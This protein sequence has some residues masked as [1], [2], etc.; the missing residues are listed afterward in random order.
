MKYNNVIRVLI[1]SILLLA[2]ITSA[3]G[4]DPPW[5][6]TYQPPSSLLPV[7]AIVDVKAG[8]LIGPFVGSA[9]MTGTVTMI[10]PTGKSQNL[11]IRMGD[12]GYSSDVNLD[13]VGNYAMEEN[14]KLT[15][16]VSFLSVLIRTETFTKTHKWNYN[17]TTAGIKTFS[18]I[19]NLSDFSSDVEGNIEV[20]MPSLS[21]PSIEPGS[22][23][24]VSVMIKA[25]DDVKKDEILASSVTLSGLWDKVSSIATDNTPPTIFISSASQSSPNSDVRI[26][27]TLL[28][29]ENALCIVE[30]EYRGGSVS[31]W[32][33]AAMSG[34]NVS[35]GS[36]I[37]YW[38][39]TMDEPNGQ[40]LYN[41]RMRASDS[42]SYSSWASRSVTLNN[43]LADPNTPP[44][45]GN[46]H[47]I[48]L[49]GSTND[50]VSRNPVTGD[51]LKAGYTFHDIDGDSESGS[52]LNWYKF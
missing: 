38:K 15:V 37:L 39:S 2:L 47:M 46:V 9:D 11:N 13:E 29:A 3:Y 44:S 49:D 4:E 52:T 14:Y 5:L 10:S 35:P 18:V 31:S 50:V 21:V 32:T 23:E 45:A 43:T 17:N 27:F 25:L 34:A 19:S 6:I 30:S 16:E 51:K 1:L 33:P 24:T 28:D 22:E 41:I 48:V 26:S 7:V 12:D 20:Y 40:G 8:A 36:R 42:L